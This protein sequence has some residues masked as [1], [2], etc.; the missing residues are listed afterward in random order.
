MTS[1]LK[2]LRSRDPDGMRGLASQRNGIRILL[3]DDDAS[4]CEGLA[5][6]LRLQGYDVVMAHD[7]LDGLAKVAEFLPDVAIFDLGLPELD[8]WELASRVRA[9]A[10]FRSLPLI[11]LSGYTEPEHVAR[12]RAVGFDH[13]LAK[14]TD[15]DELRAVLTAVMSRV[16]CGFVPP[17]Y[18]IMIVEDETLVARDLAM[19]M[20]DMGYEV[21]AVVDSHDGALAQCAHALPDVVLMDIKI[22]GDRDGID[23]AEEL[24]TRF[25]LHV[26]YLT[27]DGDVASIHRAKRTRPY[28]YLLKPVRP[29]ELQAAIE[30][31]RFK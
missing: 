20:T 25:G 24:R 6:L 10:R 30:I 11:A 21:V 16:T 27:A 4:A 8:G 22:K 12:S 29:G 9:D 5:V 28:A 19:M 3:V 17:Q 18:R 7:G 31:A 13:H 26:I 23:T 2:R 15:W 14:P 1:K